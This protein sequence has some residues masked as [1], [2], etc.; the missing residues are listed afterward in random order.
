[1]SISQ[2]RFHCE[3]IPCIVFQLQAVAVVKAYCSLAPPKSLFENEDY[4]KDFIAKINSDLDDGNGNIVYS[5]EGHG[6]NQ[7]PFNVFVVNPRSGH[8]CVTKI[9]DREFMDFYNLAGVARYKNG[10][11]AE[12]NVNIIIK[13]VDENDNSPV[14]QDIQTGG[15]NEGSPVDTPV[16]RVIATDDDE[17]GN[18]NSQIA[19]H[20]IDQTPADDLFRMNKSGYIFVKR[21]GLDREQQADGKF[22]RAL[23]D[24]LYA[25]HPPQPGELV[26]TKPEL[27]GE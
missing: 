19:Y 14:F 3:V 2:V 6:A 24:P 23:E 16:M 22:K 4:T 10:S 7:N 8:I 26:E 12:D 1:M 5:L 25:T 21:S 18:V 20:I 13:V 27:K 11:L 15:V 9:L 17:P